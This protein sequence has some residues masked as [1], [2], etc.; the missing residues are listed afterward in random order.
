MD[1]SDGISSLLPSMY[2]L[3]NDSKRAH[4]PV[5]AVETVSKHSA[6]HDTP[7]IATLLFKAGYKTDGR[8][9]ENKGL[10]GP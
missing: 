8:R 7:E 1:S 5:I 9:T 4:E 2:A 10:R 3:N 6:R